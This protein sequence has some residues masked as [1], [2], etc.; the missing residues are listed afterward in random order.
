MYRV[1]FQKYA[2]IGDMLAKIN[3]SMARHFKFSRLAAIS[4]KV[5]IFQ[6]E[7]AFPTLIE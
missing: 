1:H 7:N 5:F 4:P 3:R 2:F 6:I